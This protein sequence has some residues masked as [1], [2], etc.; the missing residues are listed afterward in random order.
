MGII[1]ITFE[2]KSGIALLTQE[3]RKWRELE[4][5]LRLIRPSRKP[6]RPKNKFKALCYD[7]TI[8][9]R[10]KFAKFMT[11]VIIVNVILMMT[12]Y[13]EE[14]LALRTVRCKIYDNF[15]YFFSFLNF[16]LR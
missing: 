2:T 3:Q 8:D 1:I 13:R 10:G 7:L 9:K 6:P 11:G 16:F 14:P 4:R 15:R 12:E 5:Q